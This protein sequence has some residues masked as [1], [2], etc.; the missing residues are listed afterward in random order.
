MTPMNEVTPDF[1]AVNGTG[2]ASIVGALLTIVLVVAVAAMIAAAIMWMVGQ[3]TGSWQATR[4]GR[5]GVLVAAGA[6]VLA[7]G[8]VAWMNFLLTTGAG[9]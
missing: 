9:M 8:G 2:L 7:G 6:A 4:R 1:S 5:V 3:A